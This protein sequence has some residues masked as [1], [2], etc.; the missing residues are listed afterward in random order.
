MGKLHDTIFI[1]N[2]ITRKKYNTQMNKKDRREKQ[3]GLKT[4]KDG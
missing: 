4:S 3:S 1:N 2:K